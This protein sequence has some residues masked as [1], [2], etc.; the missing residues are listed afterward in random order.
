MFSDTLILAAFQVQIMSVI[1]V[2]F[3]LFKSM[4]TVSLNFRIQAR[5]LIAFKELFNGLVFGVACIHEGRLIFG[6]H[7]AFQSL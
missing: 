1:S 3:L 4:N 2:M 6:V 5:G 7:F